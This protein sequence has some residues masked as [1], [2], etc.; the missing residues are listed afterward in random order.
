MRTG[1]KYIIQEVSTRDEGRLHAG[2]GPDPH[3]VPEHVATSPTTSGS[4][5]ALARAPIRNR[6][7]AA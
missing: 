2:A 6:R 5:Y 3:A 1:V 4:G 7:N